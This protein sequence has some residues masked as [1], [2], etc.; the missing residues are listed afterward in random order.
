MTEGLRVASWF[1]QRRQRRRRRE[2]FEEV[3][4]WIVVPLVCVG[5]YWGW[6]IVRD[7]VKSTP[8]MSILTGKDNQRAAP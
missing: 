4:A 6:L 8:L 2:R 1:E 7:Q 3:I 5:L